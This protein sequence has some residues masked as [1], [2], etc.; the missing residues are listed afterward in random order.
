MKEP[1]AFVSTEHLQQ[2]AV[3][4]QLG[5]GRSERQE[6]ESGGGSHIQ[7]QNSRMIRVFANLPPEDGIREGGAEELCPTQSQG[8][9]L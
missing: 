3:S 1:P 7:M 6:L 9:G 4:W 5:D 2:H 8:T